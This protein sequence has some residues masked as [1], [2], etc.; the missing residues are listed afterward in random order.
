MCGHCVTVVLTSEFHKNS[1]LHNSLG[2]HC[3]QW[4]WTSNQ[5]IKSVCIYHRRGGIFWGGIFFLF[6]KYACLS[7]WKYCRMLSLWQWQ[8][9]FANLMRHTHTHTP[10]QNSSLS[11]REE[12]TPLLRLPEFFRIDLK[13]FI[14]PQMSLWSCLFCM[15]VIW[16]EVYVP[17]SSLRPFN[18]SALVSSQRQLRCGDWAFSYHGPELWNSHPEYSTWQKRTWL[19]KRASF[20]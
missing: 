8:C 17:S 19:L 10:T 11:I 5:E 16:L 18:G 7:V 6:S 14:S 15:L 3:L 4:R 20:F 12:G 2:D 9:V 13:I 1:E